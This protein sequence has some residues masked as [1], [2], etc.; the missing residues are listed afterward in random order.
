MPEPPDYPECLKHLLH[1]KIW[2]STLGEVEIYIL[3]PSDDKPE[4]TFIKPSHDTK[5][6][7]AIIEPKDQ[8]ISCLLEGIPDVMSP[9]SPSMPVHCSEVV[10]MIS[11]Y[12]VYVINGS[13]R[14]VCQYKGPEGLLDLSVVEEAVKIFASS[15]EAVA[16]CAMDFAAMKKLG[17]PE[18]SKP[19]TCL[20][21]VN[22]GYSLGW[23]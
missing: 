17:A 1:R 12:R 18:D 23:Y 21:E 6:F 5:A 7:S 3:T 11:E 20:V 10:E 13:I 15:K 4:Q 19:I 9:L 2:S 16:G 22:D 8:M 14:S